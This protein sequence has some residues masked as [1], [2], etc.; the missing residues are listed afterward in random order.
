M[1]I[2]S[3][4]T[5]VKWFWHCGCRQKAAQTLWPILFTLLTAFQNSWQCVHYNRT[6]SN[7]IVALKVKQQKQPNSYFEQKPAYLDTKSETTLLG[8]TWYEL[9]HK[10]NVCYMISQITVRT[11]TF[12]IDLCLWLHTKQ[13]ELGKQKIVYLTASLYRYNYIIYK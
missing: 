7:S 5:K 10:T 2:P 13:T 4:S 12:F 3:A 8:C 11:L 6:N 9:Q 1:S